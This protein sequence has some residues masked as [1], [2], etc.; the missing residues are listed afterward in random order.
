M[1]QVMKIVFAFPEKKLFEKNASFFPP[2]PQ[3]FWQLLRAVIKAS[4]VPNN[5]FLIF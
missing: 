1:N 3:L 5:S 2:F 4:G